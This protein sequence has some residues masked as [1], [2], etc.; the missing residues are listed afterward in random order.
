MSISRV[1][2]PSPQNAGLAPRGWQSPCVDLR[3]LRHALKT[4]PCFDGDLPRKAWPAFG[5]VGCLETH[6]G[7]LTRHHLPSVVP[8]AARGRPWC[9]HTT[10]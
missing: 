7:L 3:L 4:R 8:E 2:D 6:T 10:P 1:L 9:R 5:K